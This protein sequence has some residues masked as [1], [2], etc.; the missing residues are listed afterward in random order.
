MKKSNIKNYAVIILI[1]LLGGIITGFVTMPG[2]QEYN[3]T[4]IKPLLSPP[5]IVF[6][7]VWSM[8]Y[9]LMAIAAA[10][11]KNESNDKDVL[12]PY[13]MQLFANYIWSF[14][15]FGF[16]AYLLAFLW[17]IL[18]FILIIVTIRSFYHT[19]KKAAYLLIPYV[20][21]TA[22]AGYLNLAV[23]ILNR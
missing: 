20:L 7:I 11:V 3:D 4:V 18:L 10:I 1:T 22:F 16:H 21:W 2:T 12:F 15:F 8:L 14:I 5:S 17:L 23:Y 6:P 19:N 9:V 13:W